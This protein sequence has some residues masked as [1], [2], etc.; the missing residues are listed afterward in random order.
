[1]VEAYSSGYTYHNIILIVSA[2]TTV[3]CLIFTVSLAAVHLSNWVK[4]HEQKQQVCHPC[5]AYQETK[6]VNR[7]VRIILFP[8][9]FAFFNF[10]S[11]WFYQ[12]S[13]ILLPFPEL[14][15]CFALVAMFYLL[16]LYVSPHDSN[17]EDHF[18]NL[19]RLH[20]FGS[21]RGTPKHDKGSLRWFKVCQ[22]YTQ[23]QSVKADKTRSSGSVFSRSFL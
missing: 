4:P 19:R 12:R 9:V 8:T 11:V 7:I 2:V 13:W 5:Y 22:T 10:F 18:Q 1:M 15:E 16:V 21:K 14:Y 23:A 3:L 20:Q 6:Y 17:R